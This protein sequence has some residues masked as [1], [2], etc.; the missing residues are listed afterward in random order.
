MPENNEETLKL[1]KEMLR[2]QKKYNLRVTNLIITTDSFRY[3]LTSDETNPLREAL[4]EMITFYCPQ[5]FWSEIKQVAEKTEIKAIR[6]ETKPAGISSVD[7]TYNLNRFGYREFGPPL[8]EG[9]KYCIEYIITA[10]LLQE[11]ARLIEAIPVILAKND[12][13]SSMLAFLSQKFE[14]AEKLMGLLK[15][16]HS[17]KP[18][19]ETAET[20]T[21]LEALNTKEIPAD[22]TSILQK[23]RLY[24]AL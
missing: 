16:L 20:I 17:I 6:T 2:L 3:M 4:S 14:T 11:D 18:T 21:Y 12:F 19:R 7:L 8:T 9:R 15:T 1:Y 23:M 5:T 24:N 10:I 22:E 13:K